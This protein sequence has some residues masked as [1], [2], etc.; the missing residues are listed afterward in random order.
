MLHFEEVRDNNGKIKFIKCFRTGHALLNTP[1]VN[2]GNAFSIEERKM[3]DLEGA[4]TDKVESLN[5]QCDRMYEMYKTYET[6]LEKNV[7]LMALNDSNSTLLYA[8]VQRHKLEMIPI[9]YTPTIGDAVENFSLQQRNSRGLYFDYNS[10]DDMDKIFDNRVNENID[11]VIV[12]DGEGVLG[13]GDQG[14]GAMDISIGKLMVYTICAGIN[15]N[16][17]LPI[18]LD[19]GTNNEKLLNDPKYIGWRHKRI[20]GKKYDDF[21][22]EFVKSL[23]KK[24]PG[25]YLHWEDFGRANARKNLNKFRDKMPTFNDDM[26]GTGIVASANVM[27]ASDVA[28]MKMKDHRVVLL[29]AGTA[30]CGV[31]DQ[32][33]DT[34]VNAGVDIGL[35][36]KQFWLIDRNG[37]LISDQSELVDFQKPYARDRHELSDW[38]VKDKNNITLSEVVH[39]VK[40]T[41]LI[42]CSTMH[43]A[44]TEEIVKFMSKHCEIPMIMPLSNPTKLSEAE[45]KDVIKWSDG[46]ALVATGSPFA[47]VEYKGRTIEI[48]QSNNA[49]VFPGLGLGIIIS[50]PKVVSHAMI[51]VAA[52][53]LSSCSP[54]RKNKDNPM[55]PN[56][57]NIS[58]VQ[59]KIAVAVANQARKEGL[60]M[61]S[62]NIDFSKEVHNHTWEAKYH[63]YVYEKPRK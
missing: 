42:G 31:T 3:F 63:P 25:V 23:Q 7:F 38:D 54:M 12:T 41:I 27:T 51:V 61:V 10:R 18:A 46:R 55:L 22:D 29:G 6:D 15:P 19:V 53:T 57:D 21:I 30:G 44:F 40:P 2:K 56:F 16:R 5:Q 24:L 35:A 36:R 60:S 17:V 58:D 14:V 20:S 32:I 1:E 50:K 39:H 45:A 48:S 9:V 47:P 26:Q 4:L 49:L 33:C 59:I 34:F 11:L 13:I 28:G 37:L 43:G 8:L 62:D 52:K